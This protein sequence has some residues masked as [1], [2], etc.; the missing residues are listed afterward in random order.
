MNACRFILKLDRNTVNVFCFLSKDR[1]YH[2]KARVTSP[3]LKDVLPG[4]IPVWTT[5]RSIQNTKAILS[6]I[7]K[8]VHFAVEKHLYFCLLQISLKNSWL[9]VYFVFYRSD[10]FLKLCCNNSTLSQPSSGSPSSMI[11]SPVLT[12][13]PPPCP[14]PIETC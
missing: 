4:H 10:G 5:P 11:I 8:T 1:N 7:E 14:R 9:T 2:T 6:F 13:T 12:H 3:G